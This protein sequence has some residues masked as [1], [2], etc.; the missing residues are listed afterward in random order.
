MIRSCFLKF[1]LACLL[2]LPSVHCEA[3]IVVSTNPSDF[4]LTSQPFAYSNFTT[5]DLTSLSGAITVNVAIGIG[6]PA[7]V[8][9]GY[10]EWTT[11]MT[12]D[13][14][15]VSGDENFNVIFSS[16]QSAFAFDYVDDSV[17]GT[18][19]LNL[20]NGATNVGSTSFLTSSPF[21]I[22]NFI[23]FKSDT[24][25]DRIELREDDG[26]NNSDEYFQ[27][28]TATAVP[29]PSSLFLL[30]SIIGF[31]SLRRGKRPRTIRSTEVLE[32]PQIES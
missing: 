23:G 31:V 24:L 17:F 26:S 15:V 2:F 20:F 10:Q 16:L 3:G 27:F 13:E 32:K 25:F 29:E 14:Y 30:T 28:Y 7:P 22:A 12:G 11:A 4:V 21:G 18:F 19:T 1:S 8:D 6:D 5:N 9:H